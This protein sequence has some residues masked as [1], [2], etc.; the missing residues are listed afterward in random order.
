MTQHY[1][2]APYVSGVYEGHSNIVV[3]NSDVTASVDINKFSITVI[4]AENET[5]DVTDF[6]INKV[7]FYPNPVKDILFVKTENKINSI[8]IFNI[9]GLK[10]FE[11]NLVD[12]KI[13][14]STLNSG[15]YFVKIETE[16]ESTFKKIIKN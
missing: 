10:V 9:N 5:L 4:E 7:G 2:T 11:G 13:D 12:N 3:I 1:S 6:S 16:N 15:I 8:S 14:L